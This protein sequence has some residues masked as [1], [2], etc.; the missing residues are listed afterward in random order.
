METGTTYLDS[1]IFVYAF[2]DDSREGDACRQ[3][4]TAVHS[5]KIRGITSSLTIDEVMYVVGK[6]WP[7]ELMIEYAE[8]LLFS[9]IIFVLTTAQFVAH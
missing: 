7:K 1:N 6:R 4:L 9:P 5:C 8:N 3:L 2:H